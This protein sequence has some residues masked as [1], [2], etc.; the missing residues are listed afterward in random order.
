MSQETGTAMYKDIELSIDYYY[1]EYRPA[2]WT[3]PDG[4]PGYP[5]EGGDFD[6]EDI[7]VNGV[8]IIG[9]LSDNTIIEI[10]EAFIAQNKE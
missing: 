5:A 9:L 8:S 7:R 3:L 1:T 6:V 10:A 2:V 4:S